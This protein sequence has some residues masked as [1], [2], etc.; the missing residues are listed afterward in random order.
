MMSLLR[1]RL[2]RLVEAPMIILGRRN[3]RFEKESVRKDGGRVPEGCGAS[4]RPTGADG[5]GR[6]R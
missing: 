6:V 4:S 1:E 5:Q 2:E 3:V